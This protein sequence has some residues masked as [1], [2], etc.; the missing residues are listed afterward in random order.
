M[1][2]KIAGL[3]LGLAFSHAPGAL[4]SAA[5]YSCLFDWAERQYPHFFSPQGVPT[6]LTSF[7]SYYR[8]YYG[9]GWYLEASNGRIAASSAFHGYYDL[10]D[11]AHWVQQAGCAD[12]GA[13][14]APDY[15]R[16]YQCFDAQGVSAGTTDFRYTTQNAVISRLGESHTLQRS[17]MGGS[18]DSFIGYLPDHRTLFAVV[19]SPP[20]RMNGVEYPLAYMLSYPWA[21]ELDPSTMRYCRLN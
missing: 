12:P 2:K 11:A 13:A 6:N 14:V 21:S 4:A 3:M 1:R 10:G 9:T 15:S 18:N 17:Q 5:Q 8:H 16:Q 20:I 7:G 19:Y